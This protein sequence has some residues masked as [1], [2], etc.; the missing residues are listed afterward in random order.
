MSYLLIFL[1]EQAAYSNIFSDYLRNTKASLS[2]CFSF[3]HIL[4]IAWLISST[5]V[6]TNFSDIEEYATSVV[7]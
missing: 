4:P 5:M 1:P 6:A 3:M 2:S 7:D